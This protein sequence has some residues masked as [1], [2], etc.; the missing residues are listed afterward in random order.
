MG[1]LKNHAKENVLGMESKMAQVRDKRPEESKIEQIYHVRPEHMNGADRLFG[2]RLLEWIDEAAGMV[3]IRHCEG[4]VVTAAIDN[5][6]FIR[7]A[8]KNDMVVVIAKMTYVGNTSMEVRVD[9]YVESLDGT[10]RPINRAYILLVAVDKEGRPT[11]VP[12]L[13][14]ENESERA[15]WE[16]GEKRRQMRAMRKE[17]GF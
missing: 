8:Y 16:A 7:G 6:R 5:L 3:A 9:S 10:R 11:K 2:G 15:E 13:I 12:G 17:E 1:R 4:D 14:L